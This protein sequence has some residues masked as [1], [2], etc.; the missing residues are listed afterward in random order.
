MPFTDR[1]KFL[2]DSQQASPESIRITEEII[3]LTEKEY[4]TTLD[5][6]NGAPLVTHLAIT[7][8]KIK[9]QETLSEIPDVCMEE[10][11]SFHNEMNFAKKIAQLLEQQYQIDFSQSEMAFLTIHLRNISQHLGRKEEKI[12]R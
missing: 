1:F 2:L 8:K 7:I 4:H 11:C 9:S 10:A 6:S 3:T 12:T 5:E